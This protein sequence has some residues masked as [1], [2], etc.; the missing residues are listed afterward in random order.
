MLFVQRKPRGRLYFIQP[1]HNTS[2]ISLRELLLGWKRGGV[3]TSST[4]RHASVCS[5][6]FVFAKLKQLI[7]KARP[8]IHRPHRSPQAAA[9]TLPWSSR[10]GDPLSGALISNSDVITK[11]REEENQAQWFCTI[12]IVNI[13]IRWSCD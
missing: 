5:Q 11:R 1:V 8:H 6:K 13:Y 12:F 3:R 7:T 9:P 2:V 4:Q 10:Q